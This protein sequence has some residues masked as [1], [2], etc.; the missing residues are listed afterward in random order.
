MLLDVER[1][2]VRKIFLWEKYICE[3][4]VEARAKNAVSK[5]CKSTLG[6]DDPTCGIV[7][8][9]NSLVKRVSFYLPNGKRILLINP[10]KWL[11]IIQETYALY[12]GQLIASMI[13]ERAKD[14]R[15]SPEVLADFN[16][17]GLN[18][19]YRWER[20]FLDDAALLAAERGILRQKK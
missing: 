17:I 8:R 1:K 6:Y 18:T 11:L 3:A 5:H 15:K 9:K 12:D 16:C 13:K 14:N 7:V 2:K 20:E 4:V 19:Y 10:E